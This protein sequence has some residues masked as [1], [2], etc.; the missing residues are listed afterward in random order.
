M[1]DIVFHSP[2]GDPKTV[3]DIGCGPGDVTRMLAARFPRAKIY[4]VDLA[5]LP[6]HV[7]RPANVAFVKGEISQLLLPGTGDERLGPD[8]VNYAFARLLVCGMTKWPE[9]VKTLVKAVR[10]G[11]WVEMHEWDFQVSENGAN[12]S[13]EWPWLQAE[14]RRGWE[15]KG[16]DLRCAQK[17]KGWMEDAGLRGVTEV[18]YRAPVGKWAVEEHPETERMAEMLAKWWPTVNWVM[19]PTLKCGDT[20]ERTEEMRLQMLRDLDRAQAEQRKSYEIVVC[21]GRKP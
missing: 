12:V 18:R 13:D 19:I 8:T 2:L 4:G 14:V 20:P 7:N 1:H 17:L 10:S 15:T 6:G 11:G 16:L 5:D 9:Y 21:Y 3:V